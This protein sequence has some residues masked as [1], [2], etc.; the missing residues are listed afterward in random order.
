MKYEVEFEM[1]MRY[2]VEVEAESEDIAIDKAYDKWE[3]ANFGDAD[4]IEGGA[5]FIKGE[6]DDGRYLD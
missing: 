1:K 3:W 6:N 4:F 5:Y 2:C